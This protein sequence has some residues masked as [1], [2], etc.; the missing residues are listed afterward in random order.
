M[1]KTEQ[2]Q[3][4]VQPSQEGKGQLSRKE[5]HFPEDTAAG[6]AHFLDTE[7]HTFGRAST[8]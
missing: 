8:T 1:C 7:A 5:L 2:Q 3:V 4:K 6:K